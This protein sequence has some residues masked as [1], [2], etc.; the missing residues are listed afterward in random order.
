[1]RDK[2]AILII[3]DSERD[4]DMFYATGFL[5]PDPFVYIQKDDEKIMVT[6]DL[7]LERAKS[8]SRVDKVLSL[9]KY[10]K[11]VKKRGKKTSKLIELVIAVLRETNIKKLSVPANFNV[12]YAD[13]LRKKGFKLE[14]KKEPFFSSRE[15]KDKHEIGYIVKT[16]RETERT[17]SKAIDCIRKSTIK[18]SFLY[19]ERGRRI[20]SESIRKLIDVELMKRGYTARHTIVSCGEQSCV[21]HNVGNGPLRANESIIFDVFPK[22]EQTGYY[23]D[24]SRTIVKGRASGTLKKMYKAVASAQ[25]LVFKAAKNGAKSDVIHRKVVKRLKSFGFKTGKIKGKMR[26][27]F[28]GTGHGIGLDVHETPRIS[29]TKYTLRTGNVVTVEP[30]LYYP[31]IGGVRLEDMILITDD[32]CINLTKFPKVLE[33]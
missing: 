3:A 21:P 25:E 6:S 15:I 29:K 10:E 26:G 27:F 4:S 1:M 28:H 8:Q 2:K 31:D 24:I 14:V 17:I 5:A 18:N 9:S 16:L 22:D 30:G 20:T 23:A 13:F 19:S 7:E 32:G 33:V 11:I 12:E